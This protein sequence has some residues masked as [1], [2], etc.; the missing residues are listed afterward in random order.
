MIEIELTKALILYSAILGA[1]VLA[2]WSYTGLRMHQ[3]RRVLE[4]QHLWRCVF[5]GY[6][7]LDEQA[8]QLSECPRC[9]SINSTEDR[10]ARAIRVRPPQ[11]AS[12]RDQS[13]YPQTRRNPSHRK[14][15][16]QRRR[17]PRKRR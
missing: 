2:I 11:Q 1:L 16:R 8:S 4:N 7:Y 12:N 10:D 15:T 13:D 3:S 14:R 9:N 5:C 17:G 6:A